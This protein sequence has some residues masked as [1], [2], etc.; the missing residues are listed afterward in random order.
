MN[1]FESDRISLSQVR[2]EWEFFFLC[3]LAESKIV[4]FKMAAIIKLSQ[5]EWVRLFCWK[6]LNPRGRIPDGCHYQVESEWMSEVF[7][8]AN[9][10]NQSLQVWVSLRGHTKIAESK[11]AKFMMAEFKM[12]AI[13]KLSENEWAWF[14]LSWCESEFCEKWLNPRW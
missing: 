5:N 11:R 1:E 10:G 2:V 8:C 13:I 6:W 7:L 9:S 12:A 4:E 3:K 14:R